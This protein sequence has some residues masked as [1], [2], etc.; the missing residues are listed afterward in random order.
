MKK[1]EDMPADSLILACK[2]ILSEY[3]LPRKIMSDVGHSFISDKFMQF[4]KT[5]NTVQATTSSYHQQSNRQVEVCIKFI[6]HTMKKCIKT[7]E[8]IHIALLQIRATPLKPGL[9]TPATML[10]Y[11][12]I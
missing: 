7:N 11:H 5:M 12:P 10:Y 8:D 9:P 2:V 4:C 1:V 3:G 6:K